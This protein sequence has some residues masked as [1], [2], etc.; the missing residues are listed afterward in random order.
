MTEI[1]V[2][3]LIPYLTHIDY[4]D[5]CNISF[6]RVLNCPKLTSFAVHEFEKRRCVTSS[7][8]RQLT[9]LK[10]LYLDFNTSVSNYGIYDLTNLTK[11][12]LSHQSTITNWGIANLTNLAKLELAYNRSITCIAHLTKLKC[13]DLRGNVLLDD[14]DIC[15]IQ[16][17]NLDLSANTQITDFGISHFTS[18]KILNLSSNDNITD[19]CLSKLTSL[20]DLNICNNRVITK[21]SVSC[22]T[23]LRKL[24]SFGS[25][26]GNFNL[27]NHSEQYL[28]TST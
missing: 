8:V 5:N 13:L 18:L 10:S 27:Y 1:N 14:D 2:H 28:R 21:C 12:H 3:K 11:L 22:L 24:Q 6:D 15:S 16:L 7:Q 17:E 9:N 19:N 20:T 26:I 25:N 23:N 4:N